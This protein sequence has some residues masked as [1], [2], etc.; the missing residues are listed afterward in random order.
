MAPPHRLDSDLEDT[1][2]FDYTPRLGHVVVDAGAGIGTE[3][4]SLSR[5]VG[6]EGLVVAIEGHPE[7]F[8]RLATICELNGLQ[9]VKLVNAALGARAGE[10]VI[11]DGADYQ[12]NT[13]VGV[14]KGSCVRLDTLDGI[15]GSLAVDRVDFLKMNIEGAELQA[16]AGF[17]HGL[18]K[19]GH[20]AIACHD[21][22]AAE[23]RAT[24]A[25][26]TKSGVR[27]FLGTRGFTLQTRDTDPRPWIRDYLYGR[28]GT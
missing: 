15:L 7:T 23:G 3:V 17:E 27:S 16:L 10:A 1:F 8:R 12:L 20:V 4:L 21:F 24:Q 18:E 5:L 22:L 2:L 9:N 13:I 11:S 14:E 28:C 25:M 26:R 19:T 6:R